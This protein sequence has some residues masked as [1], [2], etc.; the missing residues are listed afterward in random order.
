MHRPSIILALFS[1]LFY[2]FISLR[3]SFLLYFSY[4][5]QQY[6]YW[7]CHYSYYLI[8][9]SISILLLLTLY[10]SFLCSFAYYLHLIMPY[11]YHPHHYSIHSRFPYSFQVIYSLSYFLFKTPYFH[12]HLLFFYLLQTT[13]LHLDSLEHWIILC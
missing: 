11:L 4:S 9:S 8:I 12:G 1:Y 2:Y 7:V 10:H 6:P 3:H 13:I 5:I